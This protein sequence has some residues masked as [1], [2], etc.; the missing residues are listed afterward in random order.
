MGGH[1]IKKEEKVNI[2]QVFDELES[3]ESKK[4]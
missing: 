3:K 2:N 1:Q 4:I